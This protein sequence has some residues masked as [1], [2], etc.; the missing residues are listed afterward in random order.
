MNVLQLISSGLGYYGAERV[1]VTLSDAL[2]G[3]GVNTIVG[4]FLNSAKTSHLEVL[5]QAKLRGLKTERIP[6]H[7]RF[8]RR[9]VLSIRNIVKNHKIDV[10]HCHGIKPDLY[11]FLATRH[12]NIALV[13]T[14][15]LWT[16]DSAERLWLIAALERC[17]LHG[18]DRVVAVSDH[19]VP[20]VRRFGVRAVVVYNG[21]DLRPFS[22]PVYDFRRNMNWC[23]RPVIGAIGRLAASKRA[24][25]SPT[26]CAR[27]S[28][29]KPECSV[30]P[31]WRRP[32]APNPR[33]RDATPRHPRRGLFLRCSR[34]HTRT[35]LLHRRAGDAVFV[36]RTADGTA[37][38]DGFRQSRRSF[39]RW[40][41]SSCDPGA[42]ERNHGVSRRREWLGGGPAAPPKVQ[43]PSHGAWSAGAKHRRIAF[44]SELHGAAVS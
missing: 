18:I 4:A 29:R 13:S 31:C 6:C 37:G 44:L 8:D 26:S 19:I 28:A 2:Q 7:G 33:G 32:R 14:C 10:I 41:D 9:A 21:I 35:S 27:S 25:I 39:Q 36:R 16:F 20:Q 22:N 12:G 15:H 3:M 34:K 11:S 17:I 1:V 5:D 24:P 43:G 38:S 30:C 42:G 23:S 40:C